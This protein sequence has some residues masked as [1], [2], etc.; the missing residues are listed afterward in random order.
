MKIFLR[1][2]CLVLCLCLL[3]L[4]GLAQEETAAQEVTMPWKVGNKSLD[5]AAMQD[6]DD[7]TAFA[8]SRSKKVEIVA[9][10][11]DGIEVSSVYLR[12][13]SLPSVVSL[14][15][16][17]EKG[18]WA[19]MD[20]LENPGTECILTSAE[21]MIRKVRIVVEFTA[22]TAL[23]VMELRAFTAGSL[24]ANLH[25]WESGKPDVLVMAD[26]AALLDLD[27]IAQWTQSGRSLQIC[28]LIAPENPA[29]FA[30]S[31][32]DAGV[33]MTPAY[34]AFAATGKD[35]AATLK[36]WTEK[37]VQLQMVSWLRLYHPMMLASLGEVTALQTELALSNTFDK[38]YEY[39]NASIYGVWV[40][41]H[42][43]Y[44]AQE[45][46][47]ALPTLEAR[48]NDALRQA[49]AD[50]F[51]EGVCSDVSL[52]PYPEN[53]DENGF[54]TEGEF[55]FESP[56][57]GLWAY[58]SPTLQVQIVQYDITETKKAQRWFISDVRFNPEA[59][60][61]ESHS[62]VNAKTR[63][64]SV[65]P[66]QLAQT[67]K[68]VFAVN[69]DYYTYRVTGTHNV[70]NVIRDGEV[71]HSYNGNKKMSFP[72][73]DTL[74]IHTDGSLKVWSGEEMSAK[75]LLALGD[76]Q[77]ALAFG[78]Y[79][80]R[81]GELRIYK[82][83]SASMNEPRSAVGMVEPGHYVFLTCE[84]R[85]PKGPL[86]LSTHDIAML[87]YAHGVNTAFNL[88]GGSTSVLIFMGEKLNRT[89]KDSYVGNPRDMHELFGIGTSELVHTDWVN[90]KPK[91]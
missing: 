69:G 73:L 35:A 8:A 44:T 76:V 75:E 89:G 19:L 25:Q 60:A 43:L 31:L 30:D 87:M 14:Y 26:D 39:D 47:D 53:R 78:P 62:Y 61:L 59:E 29:A 5:A 54:L 33:R 81:D 17:N 45:V 28:T 21:P 49:C 40:V 7:A 79:L 52:I 66:Q 70:G 50:K 4:A 16:L 18:K 13:N 48:N 56:E 23:T 15:T 41:P 67:S 71:L 85:V 86:G 38:D 2:I 84:G 57:L 11:V 82:G 12:M 88:D 10:P 83:K 34:G 64:E 90:G 9:E 3:P 65:P 6:G 32:W 80:V 37:K 42:V 74:T 68:L 91:N 36:S 55:L 24:P 72:C 27:Q 22:S 20:T 63:N 77:D 1:L 51:S 46:T 58:L